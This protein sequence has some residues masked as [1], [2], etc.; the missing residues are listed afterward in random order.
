MHIPA[1]IQNRNLISFVYDG[2]SRIVEPH[3]L[4]VDGKG[5]GALRAYQVAGGSGS[6]EFVGWKIF[7][8]SEMRSLT[9]LPQHFAGA[10]QGYKRGDKAFSV[11]HAEL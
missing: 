3:T 9:V 10:R 2:Y 11:I 1:A 5:H 7:H 6:G 4:G 8:V